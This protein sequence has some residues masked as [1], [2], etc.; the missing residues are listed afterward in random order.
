[1]NVDAIKACIVYVRHMAV[2]GGLDPSQHGAD[3]ADAELA[4]LQAEMA[5]L[6][7]A[8]SMGFARSAEANSL[9]NQ[10]HGITDGRWPDLG[11]LLRWLMDER[12]ATRRALALAWEWIDDPEL[13]GALLVAA[14]H[15]NTGSDRMRALLATA[16]HEKELLFYPR[17][18]T[19]REL[20]K[21]PAEER[22]PFLER[23]AREAASAEENTDA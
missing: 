2:L 23:A 3:K 20:M 12:A 18:P 5:D 17:S 6:H 8:E 21:L 4:A 15:G 13:E 16:R 19:A 1:M 11:V 22:R 14:N 9:Y 7:A 10:A